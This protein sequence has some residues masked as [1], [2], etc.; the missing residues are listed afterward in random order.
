MAASL[1]MV[2]WCLDIYLLLYTVVGP[3]TLSNVGRIGKC[4][5]RLEYNS[6]GGIYEKYFDDE[7]GVYYNSKAA[8]E[9]DVPKGGTNWT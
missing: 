3:S 9:A 4:F 7:N 8:C 1:D 5:E 2:G 6:N